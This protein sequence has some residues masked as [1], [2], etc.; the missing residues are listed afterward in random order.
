LY[1]YFRPIW[2]KDLDP[3]TNEGPVLVA[4]PSGKIIGFIAAKWNGERLPDERK[5][6]NERAFWLG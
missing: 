3:A 5:S 6:E 4:E 2:D 1:E